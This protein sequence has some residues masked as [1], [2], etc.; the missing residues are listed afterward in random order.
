VDVVG[1]DERRAV[2]L[3]GAV[4]WRPRKA[5]TR[6]ELEALAQARAMIPRAAAARL[7]VVS[8]AGGRSDASPDILLK[9][10]DI[11]AAF[12]E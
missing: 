12:V 6:A 3:I 8:P 9:A 11:L 1:A 4:K 10:E 5:V 2:R 7:L